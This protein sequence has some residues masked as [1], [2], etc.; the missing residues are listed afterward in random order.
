MQTAAARQAHKQMKQKAL[1]LHSR[2]IVPYDPNDAATPE[3]RPKDGE[4]TVERGLTI[5]KAI[6]AHVKKGSDMTAMDM[7]ALIYAHRAEQVTSWTGH[8]H[9]K[10]D[11]KT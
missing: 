7:K 5:E 6:T 1:K 4:R 11:C 9:C 3:R 10:T 2:D 8:G